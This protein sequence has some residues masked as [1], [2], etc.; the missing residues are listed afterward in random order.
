MVC[1]E[2]HS[3]DLHNPEFFAQM[4]KGGPQ[5]EMSEVVNATKGEDRIPRMRT[6]SPSSLPPCAS[7][8]RESSQVPGPRLGRQG[9]DIALTKAQSSRRREWRE[10][11]E[12]KVTSTG[13]HGRSGQMA[14]G[15][16]RRDERAR[17]SQRNKERNVRPGFRLE[18]GKGKARV[19]P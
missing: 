4:T 6:V 3:P 14:R 7:C 1:P 19:S 13:A 9:A 17:G 11:F 5:R 15:H 8:L 2:L 18:F 12:H 10:F 16:R